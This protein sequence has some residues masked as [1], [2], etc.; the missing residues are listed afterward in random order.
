MYQMGRDIVDKLYSLGKQLNDKQVEI[1][2]NQ[3]FSLVEKWHKENYPHE[4]FMV[5]WHK[6]ETKNHFMNVFKQKFSLQK[7][8]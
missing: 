5:D 3:Y 1:V 7:T 4:R 2:Y 6:W 8:A